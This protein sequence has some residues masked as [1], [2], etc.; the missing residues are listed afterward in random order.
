MRLGTA[1]TPE[2]SSCEEWAHK[3]IE[4]GCQAA[5]LP[6]SVC[7]EAEAIKYGAAAKSAS[8]V[9]AEVG[10]WSHLMSPDRSIREKSIELNK[11]KLAL[12]EAANARCCVNVAGG[13]GPEWDSF[14]KSN[15]SREYHDRLVETVREIVD[16]VK[17]ENTCFVLECMPWMPPYSAENYLELINDVDRK[18][19]AA[20][21]DIVNLITNPFDYFFNDELSDRVFSCLGSRVKSCH[22]KDISM[23]HAYTVS[24]REVAC[25]TGSLDIGAYIRAARR[26]DKDMPMIIEH[27]FNER[28]YRRAVEHVQKI[29]NIS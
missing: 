27:I 5:V 14:V 7:S 12:A 26:V 21:I 13:N 8:I 11:R 2:H 24:L 20:H 10:A 1:Y 17:P 15:Y 4:F 18:G 9:I 6:D 3:I 25:G 19:F 23:E 28:D 16:A 29:A 22:I